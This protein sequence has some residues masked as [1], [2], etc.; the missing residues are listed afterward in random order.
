METNFTHVSVPKYIF[1]FFNLRHLILRSFTGNVISI[2]I[3]F[4]ERTLIKHFE[5]IILKYWYKMDPVQ[6]SLQ[7][8]SLQKSKC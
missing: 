3:L 8:L 7:V 1:F 5:K 4:Q 2:K 6:Y